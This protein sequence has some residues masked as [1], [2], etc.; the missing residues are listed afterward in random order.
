M[1]SALEFSG[2]ENALRFHAGVH[3]ANE[4]IDDA[5]R[6]VPPDKA[7]KN[8][9]NSQ[10]GPTNKADEEKVKKDELIDDRFQATDN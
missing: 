10:T 9:K 5:T 3:M 8:T 7:A 1:K 6:R 2:T 4:R